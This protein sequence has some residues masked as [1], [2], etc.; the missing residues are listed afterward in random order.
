LRVTESTNPPRLGWTAEPFQ[1]A[2]WFALVTATVHLGWI[3]VRSIVLGQVLSAGVDIVWLAPLSYLLLFMPI[4]IAG[5]LAS[6][7]MRRPV[8]RLL[9]LF[10]L[11]WLSG[12]SMLLLARQLHPYASAILALGVAA[13]LTQVWREPGS[14]RWLRNRS[15][16][17]LAILLAAAAIVSRIGPSARES[18]ARRHLAVPRAGAPNVL[19]IVLD[20]VRADHLSL[21]GYGRQTT[22]NLDRWSREGVVFER[23]IAPA[24]WT[25]PTHA[26]LFT[27][28]PPTELSARWTRR[29]NGDRPRLAEVFQKRGYVTAAFSANY[30]YATAEA[31][32]LSGFQLFRSH[33]PSVRQIG[34]IAMPFRTGF[35][36]SL[37]AARRPRGV[38]RAIRHLDLGTPY[39]PGEDFIKATQVREELLRWIDRRAGRPFFAF[40]N[41]F[42]AH[43]LWAP[44]EQIRRFAA[45]PKPIDR[46][47]AGIV[48][49]DHEVAALLEALRTR[50]LL[51]QTIVVL[52]SD[53]GEQFGEHGITDHG[54][55]L[56][57]PLLHAPL[58]IRYPG[59]VPAGVRVDDAV[60]LV[61]VP[62]TILELAG[63]PGTLPGRSLADAWRGHAP[64]RSP[65]LSDVERAI[66]N[67]GPGPTQRGAMRSLLASQ[68]HYIR[69]GD[70]VE[71]LYDDHRDPE[72]LTNLAGS[73][74]EAGILESMRQA[75]A[76]MPPGYEAVRP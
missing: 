12:F 52:T 2:V 72:E 50:G 51:D 15:G 16:V 44:T 17:A 56:Y 32:L 63:E 71:E 55:S 34:R 19:L 26:S 53:H 49:Q 6:Y 11:A 14:G 24:P 61:D 37:I 29:L 59:R 18:I 67:T 73:P 48:Y 25:L 4:G 35:W 13:R 1:L 64:P 69:N 8:V 22:P 42:E 3:A 40:L 20:A 74:A 46:Y 57:L 5:T 33:L 7:A 76:R 10:I 27:G 36:Q 47:D 28:L 23:A 9:S 68:W 31:G 54:N 58:V 41:L 21:Y 39:Y 30:L 45:A 66:G 60:S 65:V 70:G 43:E 75:L 38:L 62:A